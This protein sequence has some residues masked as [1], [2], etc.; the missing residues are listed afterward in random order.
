MSDLPFIHEEGDRRLAIG[1]RCL[2][3]RVAWSHD[4]QALNDLPKAPPT[5]WTNGPFVMPHNT[6]FDD[7][8]KVDPSEWGNSG[9]PPNGTLNQA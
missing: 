1:D 3:H 7:A 8:E 2:G 9:E 5:A 6:A 4:F